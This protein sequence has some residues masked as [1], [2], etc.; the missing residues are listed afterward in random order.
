MTAPRHMKRRL[1]IIFNILHIDCFLIFTKINFIFNVNIYIR[2]RMS[3][4]RYDATA[5][6]DALQKIVQRT[7][8]LVLINFKS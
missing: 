8:E 4:P 2:P 6:Q 3:Y 7:S 5:E 1:R